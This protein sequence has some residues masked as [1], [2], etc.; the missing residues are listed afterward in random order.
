MLFKTEHVPMILSRQKTET[1]RLWKTSRAKV[2]S[3]HKCYSGGLPISPCPDCD[4]TGRPLEMPTASSPVANAW[5]VEGAHCTTC[6]GE[7]LLQ[8]FATI[9]IL[10][11]RQ[12]LLEDISEAGAKAEGYTDRLNYLAA[13]YLI[14]QRRLPVS[15]TEKML[16][17]VVKF[18]LVE[19]Q[20]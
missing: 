12:E 16:V 7:G 18:E 1:R 14:N 15:V 11:V 8:P 13:F 9:R 2:G 20:P 4:G 5:D 17:W 3:L 10:D 19:P 6:H